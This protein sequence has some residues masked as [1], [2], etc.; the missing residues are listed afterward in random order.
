MNTTTNKTTAVRR[1]ANRHINLSAMYI[2]R[3][4]SLAL[5]HC[6]SSVRTLPSTYIPYAIVNSL[7]YGY[8]GCAFSH[9]L[10]ILSIP[11]SDAPVCSRVLYI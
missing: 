2:L 4:V 9:R 6:V 10:G 1:L 8:F 7:R 5:V 3:C 11:Y